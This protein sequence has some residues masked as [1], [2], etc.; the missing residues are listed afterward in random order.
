MGYYRFRVAKASLCLSAGI[1][2]IVCVA[3]LLSVYIALILW[4]TS[5]RYG[6]R[7]PIGPMTFCVERGN[8]HIYCDEAWNVRD[9]RR[10][11]YIV[12]TPNPTLLLTRPAFRTLEGESN[13]SPDGRVQLHFYF[14]E[15]YR[16]RER[17]AVQSAGAASDA[18]P[19]GYRWH[20]RFPIWIC[21]IVPMAPALGFAR[22]ARLLRRIRDG[23][24][25][26]CEYDLRTNVT[27]ICP[28]CG[29][30]VR[31]YMMSYV[32]ALDMARTPEQ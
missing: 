16:P 31:S 20:V 29:T 2:N 22:A 15:T 19:D 5:A 13:V 4:V 8:I 12:H 14:D 26:K 25:C 27:G 23:H 18:I 6:I 11:T 3:L 24:C 17:T 9:R 10:G 28:E 7:G 30:R 1:S 21:V 32:R